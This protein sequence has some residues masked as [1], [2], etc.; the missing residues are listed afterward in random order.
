M[1]PCVNRGDF[2][3]HFVCIIDVQKR[4]FDTES[5]RASLE[6]QLTDTQATHALQ[7]SVGSRHEVC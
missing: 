6:Q 1:P 7:D 3:H 5:V 4:L 2:T